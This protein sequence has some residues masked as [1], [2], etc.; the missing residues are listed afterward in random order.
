[1][2]TQWVYIFLVTQTDEFCSRN[3]KAYFLY[4]SRKGMEYILLK[5]WKSCAVVTQMGVF[6]VLRQR[7]V[8]EVVTQRDVCVVVRKRFFVLW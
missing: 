7:D 3:S 6:V 1:M 8:C 5:K 2:E 4:C